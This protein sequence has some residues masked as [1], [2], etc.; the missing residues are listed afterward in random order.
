MR[1]WLAVS[2]G[3]AW[4][5]W[6]SRQSVAWRSC[7]GVAWPGAAEACGQVGV[8]AP[9]GRVRDARVAAQQ[10]INAASPAIQVALDRPSCPAN[11]DTHR[12]AARTETPRG[13]R[14]WSGGAGIRTR[15]PGFGDR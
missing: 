2:G 5:A 1:S 3:T 14:R 12:R 4:R 7:S 11:L 10:A 15:V 9:A 8:A 13:L 6:F